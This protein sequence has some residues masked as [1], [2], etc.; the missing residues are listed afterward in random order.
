MLKNIEG[1]TTGR[2]I[3]RLHLEEDAEKFD[4]ISAVLSRRLMH[5]LKKYENPFPDGNYFLSIH[6]DNGA[7]SGTI[8]RKNFDNS[9]H[10]V[11]RSIKPVAIIEI[12]IKGNAFSVIKIIKIFDKPKKMGQKYAKAFVNEFAEI[13]LNIM[14]LSVV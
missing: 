2:V 3:G 8:Y 7:F 9:L 6:I 5:R 13:V 4:F 11:N 10:I 1:L 12:D 14:G